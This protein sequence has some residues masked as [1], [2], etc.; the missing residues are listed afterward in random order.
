MVLA[1]PDATSWASLILRLVIGIL[2][3]V[4]GYPKIKN[5]K[6]TAKFTKSIGFKPAMF[7]AF[8]LAATEFFGGIALVIGFATRVASVF[9]FVA[10]LVATY[11]KIFV[12]N[13][14]FTSQKQEGYE[15]D[16]VLMAGLAAI[17]LL[18]SGIWS[19]DAMMNWSLG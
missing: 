9:L 10:M 2:F 17:F 8:V 11:Y 5:L 14:P 3:I 6:K 13:S 1:I 19:L 16:L 15:W 4:H 7:W 18:S 12:W